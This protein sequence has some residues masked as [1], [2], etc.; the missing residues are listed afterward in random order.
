MQGSVCQPGDPKLTSVPPG[1]QRPPAGGPACVPH[2]RR[3]D[4]SSGRRSTRPASAVP[5]RASTTLS[6]RSSSR[7]WRLACGQARQAQRAQQAGMKRGRQAAGGA[8]TKGVGRRASNARVEGAVGQATTM[9]LACSAVLAVAKA[10]PAGAPSCAL[11]RHA[12]ARSDASK[13]EAWRQGVHIRGCNSAGP[14]RAGVDQSQGP[15]AGAGACVW[16]P[17]SQRERAPSPFSQKA[18]SPAPSPQRP[19]HH[20]P[21][22]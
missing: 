12:D 7:S 22:G 14:M 13:P 16:M 21:P 6:S 18:R 17:P 3:S 15:L 1:P 2:P 10:G 9:G 8:G 5:P 11:A 20:T 19:R 4:A